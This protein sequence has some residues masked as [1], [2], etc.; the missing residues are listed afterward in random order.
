LVG[1]LAL[2]FYP[3]GSTKFVYYVIIKELTSILHISKL[4]LFFQFSLNRRDRGVRRENKIQV[5]AKPEGLW[6]SYEPEP[7]N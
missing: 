4:A 3:A 7:V 6:Q 2:F 5:I 1:K